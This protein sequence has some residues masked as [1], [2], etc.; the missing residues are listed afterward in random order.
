ME[1]VRL[2][3]GILRRRECVSLKDLAVTGEDLIQ[4]G[5]KPGRSLGEILG[6]LLMQVIEDPEKN[7]REILLAETERMADEY[8][9]KGSRM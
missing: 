9:S 3:E 5:F 8:Q 2:Y 7:R 6:R 1:S 4:I